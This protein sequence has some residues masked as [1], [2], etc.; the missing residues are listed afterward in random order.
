MSPLMLQLQQEGSSWSLSWG[1]P[2]SR[3]T[4]QLF[5][6]ETEPQ[7]QFNSK[8]AR[9]NDRDHFQLLSALGACLRAKMVFTMSVDITNSS[10]RRLVR[11]VSIRLRSQTTMSTFASSRMTWLFPN[12]TASSSLILSFAHCHLEY[13]HRIQKRRYSVRRK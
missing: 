7:A 2:A 11:S 9:K 4:G 6:R 12:S 10:S 8:A 3:P 5:R 13:L 1:G